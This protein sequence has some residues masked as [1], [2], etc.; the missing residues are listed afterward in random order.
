MVIMDT[1]DYNR[2]ISSMI[3]NPNT[4]APIP[5]D[6]SLNINSELNL[7]LRQLHGAKV[8]TDDVLKSIINVEDYCLP[9]FLWFTKTS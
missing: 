7:L 1:L 8:L 6:P 5:S 9:S 2:E 3:D 4:Y